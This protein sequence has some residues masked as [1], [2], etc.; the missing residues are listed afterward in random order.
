[1]WF[2]TTV[3]APWQYRAEWPHETEMLLPGIFAGT[4]RECWCISEVGFYNFYKST[5]GNVCI[6][7][8]PVDTLTFMGW[9]GVVLLLIDTERNSLSTFPTVK[10]WSTIYALQ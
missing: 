6:S 8:L 3:H 9:G 1:M 5:V 10:S 2:L 7:F 4:F